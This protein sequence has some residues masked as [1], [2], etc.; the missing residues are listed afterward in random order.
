MPAAPPT[1]ADELR[2]LYDAVMAL[3]TGERAV[4]ISFGGR[5]V[6]Y[7]QNQLKGLMQLGR[8]FWRVCGADSGLVNIFTE[9]A[10][11][12]RGPPVRV[13]HWT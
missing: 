5:S 1:C 2:R 12:E 9:A 11:A 13:R 6:T 8:H 10:A 3:Q 7:Q 4:T